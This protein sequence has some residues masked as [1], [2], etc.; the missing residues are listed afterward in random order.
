MAVP[1]VRAVAHP[2]L[3]DGN[4]VRAGTRRL[5][6]LLVPGLQRLIEGALR[7]VDARP[8]LIHDVR[9]VLASGGRLV[10]GARGRPVVG[11][12]SVELLAE[13]NVV[14]QVEVLLAFRDLGGNRLRIS[15]GP[16]KLREFSVESQ[17]LTSGLPELQAKSRV[18]PPQ[19][20]L[21][22]HSLAL[23]HGVQ[24]L[25]L[26][27]VGCGDGANAGPGGPGVVAFGGH[28]AAHQLHQSLLADA[29][30]GHPQGFPADEVAGHQ[31]GDPVV[32]FDQRVI[33]GLEGERNGDR[34]VLVGDVRAVRD[35]P[36]EGHQLLLVGA[37]H[38]RRLL[39]AV[40]G[41]E[42]RLVD[43]RDLHHALELGVSPLLTEEDP[44]VGGAHPA[45]VDLLDDRSVVLAKGLHV[46]GVEQAHRTR[47]DDQVVPVIANHLDTRGGDCLA[48]ST[49]NPDGD[50][51]DLRILALRAFDLRDLT[52]DVR[53]TDH[54]DRRVDRRRVSAIVGDGLQRRLKLVTLAV[55][56]RHL[57]RR[58]VGDGQ[59]VV[60]ETLGRE[61]DDHRTNLLGQ[62]IE[63]LQLLPRALRT[64]L[65]LLHPLVVGAALLVG[66]ADGLECTLGERSPGLPGTELQRL[67]CA[68]AQSAPT[69]VRSPG[70]LLARQGIAIAT[71]LLREFGGDRRVLR[72]QDQPVSDLRVTRGNRPLPRLGVQRKAQLRLYHAG[73]HGDPASVLVLDVPQLV[74]RPRL[75][76]LVRDLPVC[77][78]LVSTRLTRA[79]VELQLLDLLRRRLLLDRRSLRLSLLDRRRRKDRHL[80]DLGRG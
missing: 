77:H 16:A 48:G 79:I 52:L 31:L 29:A 40:G 34:A 19:L 23:G 45:G 61:I 66:L 27:V 44:R 38:P 25:H 43:L 76:G 49:G 33:Q 8:Q 75:E 36:A 70:E 64:L 30:A 22:G 74:I 59:S 15:A 62:A 53:A 60:D 69:H 5:V 41:R 20:L 12:R 80:G 57:S 3:A 9:V 28:R 51:Q 68:L 21:G 7:L 26:R 46:L 18:L 14:K 50:R 71:V 1:G 65:R 42:L 10:E 6:G 47:P 54:R 39:R 2:V 63:L 67:R 56:R 17:H 35:L 24:S 72:R 32:E 78:L 11:G 37:Q 13:C 58:L 73:Q 4:G 55:H